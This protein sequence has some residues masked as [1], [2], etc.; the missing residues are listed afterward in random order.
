MNSENRRATP[1]A[2]GVII[3]RP[4]NLTDDWAGGLVPGI[5][6][7]GAAAGA[8]ALPG[9]MRAVMSKRMVVAVVIFALV[10]AA[11]GS[12]AALL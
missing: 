2:T 4:A 3:L 10:L 1:I 12:L 7:T 5:R 8:L 6:R 11:G 9:R